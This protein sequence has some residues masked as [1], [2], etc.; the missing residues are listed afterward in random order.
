M[1]SNKKA[2]AAVLVMA[3]TSQSLFITPQAI[4]GTGV[5]APTYRQ[6]VGTA[7][8]N[9]DVIR[10]QLKDYKVRVES[11]SMSASES[12][13]VMSKS[14][15]EQN[16]S[17]A[18][19]D[20]Y[21]QATATATEYKNFKKTLTASL[22][23]VDADKVTPA[24]MSEILATTLQNSNVEGLAWSGCAGVSIGAILL[25]AAVVVGIVAL[26]KTRGEARIRKLYADRR[27]NRT[28]TY[29]KRVFEIN[30][31]TQAIQGDIQ[32]YQGYITSNNQTIATNN[33]KIQ[34]AIASS[35]DCSANTQCGQNVLAWSQQNSQLQAD[36]QTYTNKISSLNLELAQWQDQ[37]YVQAQLNLAQT[38][39]NN[40]MSATN[41]DEANAV[42]LI[43]ANKA[44]AKKLGIGA[45]IGGAIGIYLIIDGAHDGG[46]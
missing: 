26:T 38:D 32:R 22:K 29:N 6:L 33:G 10:G 8:G 39:Y 18:D 43:P 40:D 16:I 30:N 9:A 31:K 3:F 42:A 24:Q 35:S 28:E 46:C 13:E 23:G 11:G 4:A 19:I 27:Q 17:L 5:P 21:V 37:S 36:N 20:A 41:Q 44:L 34:G 45:G 1:K 14:M 15:I 2:I 12:I 7:Q 25:V